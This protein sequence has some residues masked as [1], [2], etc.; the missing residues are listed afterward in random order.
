MRR[1]QPNAVVRIA[2]VSL[3]AVAALWAADVFGG[4][5][6][7]KVRGWML[8]AAS[9]VFLISEAFF[10]RAMDRLSELPA[11]EILT[12][13]VVERISK[14]TATVKKALVNRWGMLL[15]LKVVAGFA[16]VWLINQSDTAE[17]RSLPWLVGVFCITISFPLAMSFLRV[18]QEA[19]RAKMDQIIQ[20][21][22]KKESNSLLA[23]LSAAPPASLKAD[24]ML[25]GYSDIVGKAKRK[26]R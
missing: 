11:S 19:D 3:V 2:A 6:S 24:E 8:A 25:A 13:K 18:W 16:G 4:S 9:T 12:A 17:S 23:E 1:A 10:W 20:A 7:L 26:S 21:K 15:F 14:T 22:C 5:L